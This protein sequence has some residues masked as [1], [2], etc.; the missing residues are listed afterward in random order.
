MLDILSYNIHTR[1]SFMTEALT[2]KEVME[3]LFDKLFVTPTNDIPFLFPGTDL[4]S[5][6]STVFDI[7]VT[8]PKIQTLFVE[9][10]I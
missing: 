5:E 1:R 10:F 3:A 6:G 7:A 8:S 2:N 9:K 4:N